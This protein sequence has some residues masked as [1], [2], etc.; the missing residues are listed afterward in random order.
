MDGRTHKEEK[1]L[2]SVSQLWMTGGEA[3]QLSTQGGEGGER[4]G[5]SS[6]ARWAAAGSGGELCQA[7]VTHPLYL[8]GQPKPART[9]GPLSSSSSLLRVLPP[10]R[11]EG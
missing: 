8:R 7:A 11:A 9:P 6:L 3:Y 5:R 10:S 2:L 1:G 4:S